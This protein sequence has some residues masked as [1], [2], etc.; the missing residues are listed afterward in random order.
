MDEDDNNGLVQFFKNL[1]FIGVFAANN[2]AQK[3]KEK[4]F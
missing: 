1:N 2:F 3:F 4:S